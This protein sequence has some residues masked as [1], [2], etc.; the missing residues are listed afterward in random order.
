MKTDKIRLVVTASQKEAQ[1]YL[2][3]LH[4]AGI[5]PKPDSIGH[6]CWLEL[7]KRGDHWRV[8]FVHYGPFPNAA[9]EAAMH[10]AFSILFGK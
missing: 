10:M 5:V 3:K 1:E 2:A 4:E 6:Y 9:E 7:E 8:L